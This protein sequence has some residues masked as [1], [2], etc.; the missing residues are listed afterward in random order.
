MPTPFKIIEF[1][2]TQDLQLTSTSRNC[3]SWPVI[4]WPAQ[5]R[6][7]MKTEYLLKSTVCPHIWQLL[8]MTTNQLIAYHIQKKTLFMVAIR[9]YSDLQFKANTIPTFIRPTV[10]FK[11]IILTKEE[12]LTNTNTQKRMAIVIWRYLKLKMIF[13]INLC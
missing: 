12:M 7:L 6:N 3:Y 13:K 2:S 1:Q 9:R 4:S 10:S 8:E 5:K 11:L